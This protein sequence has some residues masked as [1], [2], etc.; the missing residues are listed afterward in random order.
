[1]VDADW[2]NQWKTPQEFAQWLVGVL[3]SYNRK[4]KPRASM[5]VFQAIGKHGTHPIFD[6]IRMLEMHGWFFRNWITWKKRRAFGKSHDYLFVREEILWFSRSHARTEVTYNIPL[7]DEKRGYAGF[8]KGYSAKSEYKRVGNVMTDFDPVIEDCT[9]L[10]RP[11][12]VCQKPP[13]LMERLVATHSNLGDLVV[14]PF[15]G[16]G[17][18][19]VAAVKLGRRFVGAEAISEDAWAANARVEKAAQEVRR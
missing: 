15:S 3:L 11:E 13:R 17:S 6:V 1:M 7:L 12:R 5:L 16:W 8:T 10:M 2:D 18:T 4:L 19:G 14:D 9:E